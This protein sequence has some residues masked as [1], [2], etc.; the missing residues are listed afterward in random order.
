M[1]EKQLG[2]NCISELIGRFS[3]F[4]EWCRVESKGFLV[5]NKVM[6]NKQ[7]F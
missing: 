4:H 3:N 2:I 1:F 7:N 5:L 6:L